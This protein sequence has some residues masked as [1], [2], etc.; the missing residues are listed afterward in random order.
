MNTQNRMSQDEAIRKFL[1]VCMDYTKDEGATDSILAYLGE[2]YGAD[3]SYICVFNGES[4]ETGDVYEWCRHDVASE[5]DVLCH[6]SSED[7]ECLIK[8]FE[9]K[10]EFFVRFSDEEKDSDSLIRHFP[11]MQGVNSFMA[12]P[13]IFHDKIVGF[14]GICNPRRCTE[15]LLLLTV[16]ASSCYSEIRDRQLKNSNNE[17]SGQIPEDRM[18]I[19]QSLSEIYTSVYF[20]DIEKNY[21]TEISSVSQVHTYIGASGDAQEQLNYFCHHMVMPEFTDEMLEFVNL[22]TMN[23]R[24]DK[25]RILSKQYRSRVFMSEKTG[26]WA[27][28]CF[29]E[30]DRDKEGRLSHVIFATQ[31]IHESKVRELEAQE[32]LQKTNDELAGLLKAEKQHTAIIS[33]LSNIFFALYFIDLEKNSF[34]ELIQVDSLH[35][36]YSQKGNARYALKMLVETLVSEEYQPAMRI[37]TDFDTI[38]MRLKE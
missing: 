4:T 24:F 14:L 8:V 36:V 18:K 22:S 15:H 6:I 30:S 25:T 21:F 9:E 35:H 2:Y 17:T 33:A 10:G 7:I 13:L 32:K 38:D 28:C 3:R 1:R 16:A 19:I 34:Q 37:F 5:E 11:K 20:I 29:I 26:N 23:D 27:E 12:A 31:S